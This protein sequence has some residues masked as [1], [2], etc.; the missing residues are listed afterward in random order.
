MMK[1]VLTCWCDYLISNCK[2]DTNGNQ[3]MAVHNQSERKLN[4]SADLDD[5]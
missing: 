1:T 5:N 2:F 4:W 3:F